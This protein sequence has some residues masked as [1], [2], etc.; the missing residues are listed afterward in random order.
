MSQGWKW[1]LGSIGAATLLGFLFVLPSLLPDGVT[2]PSFMPQKRIAKGLDLQGGL[3]LELKVQTEKAVENSLNRT[4]EDISKALRD[5]RVRVRGVDVTPAS[6][7]LAVRGEDGGKKVVELLEKR[8]GNLKVD[9]RTTEGEDEKF[10]LSYTDDEKKSIEQYAIDQGIETIRNRIDQFGVAEPV[11]VPRGNG[12]IL[13][14][15]PGLGTL[16]ADT[17]SGWLS[18]KMAKDGVAGEVKAGGTDIE[19]T[20][21][22][23]SVADSIVA[24]ATGR[25]VG[26]VREKREVM[27]D[28]KV[29]V[30][31][32]LATSKRAKK[33]IGQTA[34][35]EFR[36]LNEE[37]P[38]ETAM[39]TGTPAGSEILYGK[40]KIDIRTGNEVGTAPAYL[41]QKRV[42]MTGEVVQNAMMNV[43]QN[44]AEY[45]VLMEFDKRGEQIFGDVTSANVGKRLAI[46]LDGVVQSAP[47]IR[48]AI[49][50]GRASISGTFTRDEARDLA[51]A[52][53]SGSLPAPVEVLQEI[54]VG[55]SLG[56]DSIAAGKMASSMSLLLIVA[57]MIFY[58]R[59]SGF[60]ADLALITNMIIMLGLLAAVGATL[61]LPGIAGLALTMGMAVDA[62]VLILER[63]R[64]ELRIG[65]SVLNAIESG[66]DKAFSTIIDSN[67]TTLVAAV[68]L[69]F[70]GSGPVKG[71]AVTLSLGMVSSIFTAIV[72]TRGC[73]EWYLSKR[74][75]KRLSI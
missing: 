25:F 14:Q 20:F 27:P 5:E 63:I 53:R 41:V 33:L 66:Y 4:A 12:E 1:R 62:N 69:Y 70:M 26:L 18:D 55:A 49:L 61:T 43:D 73:Y 71:F 29:K 45:Y 34:Q 57:F 64:E 40:K 19:V 11:I 3:H 37:T 15:L 54:E 65:K 59:W 6:I 30:L 22:S 50:G 2:P 17:V 28:G 10:V 58:Y 75:V 52:L 16:S 68:V 60:I 36:L 35:L 44:R 51:I 23:E 32:A 39:S 72:F 42:I 38:V 13:I 74:S 24:D 31:F 67:L 48:E 21:P 56:A 46:L 7:V 9:G 47:V 8:F